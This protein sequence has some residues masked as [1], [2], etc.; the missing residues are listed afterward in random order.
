MCNVMI[1]CL[2]G[3]N[4]HAH[5][6]ISVLGTLFT[7]R[8][9]IQWSAC[10]LMPTLSSLVTSHYNNVIMGVMASQVTSLKIVYSTIHSGGDQR[11]H[12]SS[13]SLAFVWGIHRWPVNSPHKGPVMRKMFPFDDVIM[14][15]LGELRSTLCVWPEV[16]HDASLVYDKCSSGICLMYNKCSSGICLVYEPLRTCGVFVH[17]VEWS[18]PTVIIAMLSFQCISRAN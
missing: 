12:Q 10:F 6:L 16:F 17:S 7:G 2:L 14:I 1:I 18:S 13:V 3:P 5:R 11:K 4:G 15:T 8:G 9:T